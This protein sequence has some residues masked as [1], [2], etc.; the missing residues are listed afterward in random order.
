MIIHRLP[1]HL[2]Y[3]VVRTQSLT[4]VKPTILVNDHYSFS[5]A[6]NLSHS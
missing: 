1:E 6:Q 2:T 4:A 5:E 3:T